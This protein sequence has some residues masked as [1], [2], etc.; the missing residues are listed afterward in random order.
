MEK[1][2]LKIVAQHPAKMVQ[3]LKAQG[4]NV[5]H[6]LND[7]II[8]ENP[9]ADTPKELLANSQ[10]ITALPSLTALRTSA[11]PSMEQLFLLAWEQRQ[12][13]EFR[14]SVQHRDDMDK[15]WGEIFE[16]LQ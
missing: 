6:R 9:P 13:E 15:D 12:S 1:R 16:T 7:I 2:L 4:I 5:L 3:D 8:V 14:R 10:E 11:K